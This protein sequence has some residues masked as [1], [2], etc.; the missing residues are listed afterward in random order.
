MRN[1]KLVLYRLR[2]M[3]C[4]PGHSIETVIYIGCKDYLRKKFVR[5]KICF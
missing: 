4:S 3:H 1:D 5:E 2:E